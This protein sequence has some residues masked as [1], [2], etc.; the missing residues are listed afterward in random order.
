[1]KEFR[2]KT[3][4]LWEKFQR[5]KQVKGNALLQSALDL[6]MPFRSKKFVPKPEMENGSTFKVLF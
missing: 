3:K 6:E 5:I 2:A 4:N 1:M